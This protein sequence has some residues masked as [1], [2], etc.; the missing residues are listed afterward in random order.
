[1]ARTGQSK[2]QAPDIAD[3]AVDIRVVRIASPA[4]RHRAAG[5]RSRLSAC[6]I[7]PG[8]RPVPA[9]GPCVPN[10]GAAEQECSLCPAASDR[11]RLSMSL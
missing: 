9:V 2:S 1:M 8:A 3:K 11:V 4:R 10:I 7:E 5:D 6:Q